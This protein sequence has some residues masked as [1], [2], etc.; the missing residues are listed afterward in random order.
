MAQNLAIKLGNQ[1]KMM[2]S[3]LIVA[4]YG[5]INVD[6]VCCRSDGVFCS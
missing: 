4:C 1:V 3:L 5:T 6:A 2:I